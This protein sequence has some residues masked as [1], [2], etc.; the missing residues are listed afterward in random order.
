MLSAKKCV[1]NT[2]FRTKNVSRA[3]FFPDREDHG[4]VSMMLY[5]HSD[6]RERETSF[7][8][9]VQKE[10][11]ANSVLKKRGAIGYNGEKLK[12]ADKTRKEQTMNTSEGA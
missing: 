8:P 9:A 5:R 4:I 11:E 1:F 6:T 3:H 12:A 10:P 2:L 7:P